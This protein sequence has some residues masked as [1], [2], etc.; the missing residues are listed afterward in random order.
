MT[1]TAHRPPACC[2]PSL[3]LRAMTVLLSLTLGARASAADGAGWR[4]DGHGTFPAAALPAAVPRVVWR[5]PLAAWGNGSPVVAA[6]KVCVTSEPTTLACYDAAT[7]AKL[8][9]AANDVADAVAASDAHEIRRRVAE[10]DKLEVELATVKSSYSQL[11]RAAA[12]GGADGAAAAAQLTTLIARMGTL[13]ATVEAAA[14]YRT[15]PAD[16]NIGWSAPT[17][18]TDGKRIWA[19]FANGVVSCFDLSGQRL[20][21]RWLGPHA[22]EMRAYPGRATASP[23][24]VGGVLVVAYNMLYGLDAT[25]G[26]TRWTAGKYADYGSP[27]TGSVE[28]LGVVVTP[29]GRLLRASDGALLQ[30]SLGDLWYAGPLLEGDRAYLAGNVPTQS[31]ESKSAATAWSLKR[32]GDSVV[33]T[34]LWTVDLQT[35]QR[36][37]TSP[38]VWQGRLVIVGKDGGLWSLDAQTGAKAATTPL[39]PPKASEIWPSPQRLGA[40]L[41][42]LFNSGAVQVL[43]G[44]TLTRATQWTLPIPP[45]LATPWWDRDAIYVRGAT[46]LA[47]VAP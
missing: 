18:V 19:F 43:R 30:G 2:R 22:V 39:V 14:P 40:D 15:P 47:R 8:W 42:V 24:M 37:Y 7:G 3:A 21:S 23:S 10:A 41:V 13:K 29:D 45:S 5:V 26:N 20:W 28:G 12:A 33:A 34:K 46:E 1:R 44:A 9:Q 35:T 36:I 6:G 11:R 38:T 27:A 31:G 32:S 17:P 25:T 4:G 16:P